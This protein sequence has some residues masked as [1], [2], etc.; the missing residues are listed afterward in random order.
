MSKKY[1]E[2]HSSTGVSN[3][4]VVSKFA[5]KIMSKLGWAEYFILLFIR[6]KG[7]G[8]NNDGIIECIQIRKREE[9]LGVFEFN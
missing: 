3:K 7:L 1:L 6:G 8:K 4:K 9:N 5:M 2:A